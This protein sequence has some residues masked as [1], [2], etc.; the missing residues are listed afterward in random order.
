MKESEG[1][2]HGITLSLGPDAEARTH[3]DLVARYIRHSKPMGNYALRLTRETGT[4][5]ILSAFVERAD[6]EAFAA[7]VGGG[8]PDTEG[9]ASWW[10]IDFDKRRQAAL[11]ALAPGPRRGSR[12]RLE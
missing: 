6:A 5:R 2:A 4:P 10:R 1:S 11:E 7:V 3:F 8:S 12:P 9:W